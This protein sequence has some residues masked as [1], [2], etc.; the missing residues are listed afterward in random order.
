M[1]EVTQKELRV[2]G[3]IARNGPRAKALAVHRSM[4][5]LGKPAQ[6]YA[7]ARRLEKKGLVEIEQALSLETGFTLRWYIV[8]NPGRQL[9]EAELEAGRLIGRIA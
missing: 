6:V 9:L 7:V 1:T 3:A 5:R 8:M 2:L 4:A